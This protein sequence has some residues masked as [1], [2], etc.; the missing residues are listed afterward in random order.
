MQLEAV[1]T[2]RLTQQGQSEE[3]EWPETQP[4]AQPGDQGLTT[5][6]LTPEEVAQEP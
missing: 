2:E 6:A 5:P 3:E 1:L 4:C